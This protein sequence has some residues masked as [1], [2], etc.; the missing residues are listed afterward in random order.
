M[1][2]KTAR[3]QSKTKKSGCDRRMPSKK[4]ARSKVPFVSICTPT[5]NRRPFFELCFRCLA[6]QTYPHNR[7]EWLIYDDGTDPVKDLVDEFART[8]NIKVRYFRSDTFVPLS[9]KRNFLNAKADGAF[10]CYWDD[11]DYYQ[12]DRI[13][14]SVKQLQAHPERLVAGGSVMYCYFNDTEEVWKLGPYGDNHSTAATLFFRKELLQ[15]TRFDERA[16]LAEEKAFLKNYTFPMVQLA[17]NQTIVVVA[18]SQN[19]FDKHQLIADGDTEFVKKTKMTLE[20]VVQDHTARHFITHKLEPSLQT[21]TDGDVRKKPDV[22]LAML[23]ILKDRHE[24]LKKEY[25]KVA[26]SHNMLVR[27]LQTVQAQA[28]ASFQQTPP[29][30]GYL[31][32]Q[33]TPTSRSSARTPMRHP[34]AA[35]HGLGRNNISAAE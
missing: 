34:Q 11:D 21:Y 22:L 29:L 8:S 14:H 7:L 26:T 4:K 3:L 31:P 19:S 10:L 5:F 25:V 33:S 35:L 27:Q 16:Y 1:L 12:P 20:H 17:P 18:H 23:N 6:N 28:R 13:K 15:Q 2:V 30:N 24:N 9:E 32:P